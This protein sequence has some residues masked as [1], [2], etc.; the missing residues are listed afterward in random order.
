MSFYLQSLSLCVAFEHQPLV[1]VHYLR[2]LT[3]QR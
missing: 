1:V 3:L 2:Y